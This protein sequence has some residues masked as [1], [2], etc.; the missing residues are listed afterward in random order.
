LVENRPE[1]ISA[2]MQRFAGDAALAVRCVG[3]A[4]RQVEER[5]SEDRMVRRTELVYRAV[6]GGEKP[7]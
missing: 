5:F 7:A 2:A 1:A 4:R 3:N 6:L